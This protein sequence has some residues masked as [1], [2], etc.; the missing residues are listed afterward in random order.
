MDESNVRPI[1]DEARDLLERGAEPSIEDVLQEL[2]G[3]E[4]AALAAVSGLVRL[5]GHEN[6]VIRERASRAI[7]NLAEA[8]MMKPPPA[9]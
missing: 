6:P 5:W 4:Q 2:A 3:Y 8:T 1:N 7:S 9:D